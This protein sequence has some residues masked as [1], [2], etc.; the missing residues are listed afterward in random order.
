MEKENLH[1]RRNSE[2]KIK[3]SKKTSS[4]PKSRTFKRKAETLTFNKYKF[5][6]DNLGEEL[7]RIQNMRANG[8]SFA[9]PEEI[10]D[11]SIVQS[12]QNLHAVLAQKYERDDVVIESDE[13]MYQTKNSDSFEVEPKKARPISA[14]DYISKH[15]EGRKKTRKLAL[16]RQG[17][18]YGTTKS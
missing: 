18:L 11:S 16:R 10:S 6:T 8:N 17:R 4:I 12:R 7:R 5:R 14:H 2:S 13:E 9:T 3:A 15:T 1:R